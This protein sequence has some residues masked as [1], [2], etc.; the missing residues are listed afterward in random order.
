M[1]LNS[2]VYPAP[3]PTSDA[4][5]FLKSEDPEMRNMFLLVDNVNDKKEVE[6]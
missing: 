6:Y 1:E 4:N 2:V 5:F 3:E